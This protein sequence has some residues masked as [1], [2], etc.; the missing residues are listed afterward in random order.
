M[1][2]LLFYVFVIIFSDFVLSIKI[3]RDLNEL[4]RLNK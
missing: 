1:S 4:K 2:D 3:L